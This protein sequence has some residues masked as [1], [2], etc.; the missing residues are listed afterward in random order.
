MDAVKCVTERE[1]TRKTYHFRYDMNKIRAKAGK[2]K[3]NRF[4]ERMRK[5]HWK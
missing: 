2:I 3:E 5:L 4:R 1:R